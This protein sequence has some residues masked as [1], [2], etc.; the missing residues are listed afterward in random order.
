MFAIIT[1]IHQTCPP[2]ATHQVSRQSHVYG[3]ACIQKIGVQD[4]LNFTFATAKEMCQRDM[5]HIV[6]TETKLK[7]V[8]RLSVIYG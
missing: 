4:A 5:G 3:G 7:Q 6:K 8:R 1:G 2:K